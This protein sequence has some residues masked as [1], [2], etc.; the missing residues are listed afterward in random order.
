VQA[1]ILICPPYPF[2]LKP[3]PIRFHLP[4]QPPFCVV[5]ANQGVWLGGGSGW[6]GGQVPH[7]GRAG[8]P[9]SGISPEVC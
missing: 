1:L 8:R 3:T 9:G 6:P 2:W 4:P 5:W 7:S